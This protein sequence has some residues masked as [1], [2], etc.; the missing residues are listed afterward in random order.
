M[1]PFILVSDTK[2]IIA[3]DLKLFHWEL[4][5]RQHATKKKCKKAYFLENI[6][7]T[8]LTILHNTCIILYAK[9]TMKPFP[10]KLADFY[11]LQ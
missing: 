8:I 10:N 2:I 7:A 9:E 3:Q 6:C 5:F 11:S 1:S 4:L